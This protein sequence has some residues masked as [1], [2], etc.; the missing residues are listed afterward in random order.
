MIGARSMFRRVIPERPDGSRHRPDT[1]DRR[2]VVRHP[3]PNAGPTS[4][5]PDAG[6]SVVARPAHHRPRDARRSRPPAVADLEKPSGSVLS[7][8]QWIQNRSSVRSS[9]TATIFHASTRTSQRLRRSVGIITADKKRPAA[10][11]N[12]HGGTRPR[13]PPRSASS[14][15]P[16]RTSNPGGGNTPPPADRPSGPLGPVIRPPTADTHAGKAPD[17]SG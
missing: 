13:G 1:A 7:I 3:S 10:A 2:R 12:T 15:V 8:G 5:S 11:S 4:R 17:V 6:E 9:A 16:A 14:A